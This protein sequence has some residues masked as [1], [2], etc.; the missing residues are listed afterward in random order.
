M[1]KPEEIAGFVE[2]YC[3]E[4]LGAPRILYRH[5]SLWLNPRP[6]KEQLADHFVT[7][8]EFQ[9]LD[10]GTLLGTPK[11]ELIEAGV[12]MVIPPAYVLDYRL[13]VD[14]L[15]LAARMQRAAGRRR[16]GAFALLVAA[17]V[18]LAVVVGNA[19]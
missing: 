1:T 17:A 16:A 18:G 7:L 5:R 10:L 13:I 14:G 11:G 19:S 15:E 8:M 4:H 2:W 3:T 9:L 12:G 6:S